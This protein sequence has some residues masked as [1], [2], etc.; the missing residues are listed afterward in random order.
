MRLD[1]RSRASGAAGCRLAEWKPSGILS[2]MVFDH[3][4]SVSTRFPSRETE[5][6][7]SLLQRCPLQ[8]L[9]HPC[10]EE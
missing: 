6:S 4:G 8:S 9:P 2:P 5:A 1:F 3:G 10:G 7:F